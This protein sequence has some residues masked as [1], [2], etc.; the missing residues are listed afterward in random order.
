T[1]ALQWLEEQLLARGTT[2][3]DMVHDEHQRQGAANVTVRNIITSMRLI[4]EVHWP[5]FFEG[6][7]LVDA[8]LRRDTDLASMDFTT[9]ALYRN[10][11]EALSRRSAHSELEIAHTLVRVTRAAADSH[12]DEPRRRDPGYHLL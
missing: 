4:S 11:V 12:P 7:S 2:P 8:V 6:V 5:E 10:A 1:P 9:R 3:D